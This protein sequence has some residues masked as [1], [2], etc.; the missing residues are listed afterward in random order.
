MN[1][2]SEFQFQHLE[3]MIPDSFK[4]IWREGMEGNVF[5]LKICGAGGGGF[6]LGVTKNFEKFLAQF[7]NHKIIGL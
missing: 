4:Q 3:K 5:K 7:P 1:H 2:I 6:I